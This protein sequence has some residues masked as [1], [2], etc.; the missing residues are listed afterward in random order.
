MKAPSPALP[1]NGWCEGNLS[2]SERAS[3]NES[4]FVSGEL[5]MQ[6]TMSARP[7]NVSWHCEL[8]SWSWKSSQCQRD[9]TGQLDFVGN[10]SQ[11]KR[12]H[13]Q[14]VSQQQPHC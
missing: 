2:A 4:G 1:E 14:C 10:S 9:C 5:K 11:H 12:T 7:T 3:G 6:L 13:L 8:P